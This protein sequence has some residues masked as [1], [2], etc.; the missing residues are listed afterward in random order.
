MGLIPRPKEKK[1]H[2]K[3]ITRDKYL[4]GEISPKAKEVFLQP[5][6]IFAGKEASQ[7]DFQT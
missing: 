6:G 1:D 5:A 3:K 4:R 2:G 7:E